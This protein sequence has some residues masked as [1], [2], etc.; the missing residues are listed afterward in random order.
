MIFVLAPIFCL[1]V[2]IWVI[3]MYF[4]KIPLTMS[5]AWALIFIFGEWILISSFSLFFASFTT[6]VLHN[7]FLVGLSFLGHYSNDLRLFA[8]NASVVWLKQT[9]E[10][11]L[12][13]IAQ[14]ECAQFP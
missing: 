1:L 2:L 13:Y 5:H 4:N 7:F 8:D 9:T 14:P 6:P 3:L 10:N 11:T 12:L